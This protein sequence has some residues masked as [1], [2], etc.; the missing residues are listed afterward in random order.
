M[1]GSAFPCHPLMGITSDNGHYFRAPRDRPLIKWR[2]MN[3]SRKNTG[4]IAQIAAAESNAISTPRWVW[5]DDRPTGRVLA[6]LPPNMSANKN[7]FQLRIK[8]RSPAAS[9]PGA[10][11][12]NVTYSIACMRVAPSIRA[13]CSRKTISPSKK[14]TSSQARNGRL[15]VTW[16]AIRPGNVLIKDVLRNKLNSGRTRMTGGSIWLDKV[17][18]RNGK[19]PVLKRANE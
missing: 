6:W 3:G 15:M 10:A 1:L 18:R 11:I 16:A 14:D 5:K 7:S 19:P 13:A 4:K 8:E 2:L 9:I 12:G 17:N